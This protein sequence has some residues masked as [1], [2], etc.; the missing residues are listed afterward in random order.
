[1]KE[2][3][4]RC[5][6]KPLPGGTWYA[7]CIDLTLD[8]QAPT[9]E[10]VRERLDEV[11]LGYL[12]TVSEGGLEQELIPRPSPFSFRLTYWR[13]W[14][15]SLV[16]SLFRKLPSGRRPFFERTLAPQ[17]VPRHA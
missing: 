9:F 2:I 10:E 13:I 5:Y 6:A 7:H 17:P 11:I 8:T 4:L 14:V 1:M 16:G 3:A 15:V 12:R